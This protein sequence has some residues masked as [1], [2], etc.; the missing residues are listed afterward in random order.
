[1]NHKLFPLLFLFTTDLVLAQKAELAGINSIII[2]WETMGKDARQA[3]YDTEINDNSPEHIS[4]LVNHLKIPITVRVNSLGDHTSKEINL[5]LDH[6]AKIIMLPMAK[7]AKEVETFIKLVNGRAKTL[8]QIENQSLADEC[9]ELN[10]L[11]WDYA[12]LGLNDL[13]ICRGKK[14][15]WEV[16]LDET[17]DKIFA[18]LQN[19]IVGFGALTVIG[20]GNPIPFTEFLREM[21]YLGCGIT[22][23]RRTFKKEIIG[24]D[25][26]TEIEAV[27][28]VWT[29]NCL[30]DQATIEQ[31]HQNFLQRIE[32][33]K[34]SFYA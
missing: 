24:R 13:M 9:Y 16:F 10:Q 5:A 15:L 14:C 22:V 23:M 6:G 34:D 31:D 25:L 19:R 30:R 7:T 33:V 20:G 32:Q 21:N 11:G 8:I 29:A 12:Y 27:K 26:K 4:E 1:M 3:N 28:G 18:Q 2:D 17:V